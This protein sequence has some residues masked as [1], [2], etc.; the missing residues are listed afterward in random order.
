MKTLTLFFLIV[1]TTVLTVNAQI[2]EGNWMVGG[3]ASFY[4]S[5]IKGENEE[6][7]G[8]SNGIRLYPNIGY[9]FID[10]FAGGLNANFNYGKPS[11]GLSNVGFGLGPFVRYYFLNPEKRINVFADANYNYYYSKTKGFPVSNGSNYRFKA[12]P[13]IYFNSSVGLELT[14]DYSSTKFDTYTSNDFRFALG[15]QIH[16]EK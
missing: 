15:L 14:L 7:L 12:G 11:G 6:S 10:Q 9:F 5:K 8:S 2:T 13:V 4:N 3:D 16:L 1:F